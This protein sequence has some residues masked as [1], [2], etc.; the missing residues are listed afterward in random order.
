MLLQML[1]RGVRYLRTFPRLI[2]LF[3]NQRQFTNLELWV[4]ADHAGCVRSRKTFTGTVLQLGKA[5]IKTT[6][7][8]Q[9]VIAL[10]SEQ[11]TL[12]DWG[13]HVPIVGYMDAT[14]GLAI[15][16]RHGLGKVKH[17][18]TGFLWAQQVVL[19]G[20]AKLYKKD[21][22]DMQIYSQGH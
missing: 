7:K 13:I 9:A 1:K 14:T 15:G 6:C 10:S 21:T 12:K 4:D 5:T 11:S 18:D 19:E 17:I 22:E 16:S 8:S 2:H 3:P 20:K